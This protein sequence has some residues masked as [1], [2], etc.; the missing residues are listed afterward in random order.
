M[1]TNLIA[2]IVLG[3][4]FAASA[5][6]IRLGKRLPRHHLSPETKEAVRIGMG[7][8]A[9]M[10]ALVLGLLVASAKTA[11]DKEKAEVVQMAGKIAFL[12][13]VLENYGPASAEARE[14]L[15][16]AT[17]AA[18]LRIW[19][20]AQVGLQAPAP[21]NAWGQALPIAIQRLSPSDD[22][23]RYFKS[24][25][26]TLANELGQMRWLLFEQTE[27]SISVP[28]LVMMVFWLAMTFLSVGLFAPPNATVIAAQF[29]AALA[30]AGAVFLVLELDDPFSGLVKISSHSMLSALTTLSH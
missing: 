7:S 6:G 5:L 3:C 18:I 13:Q 21:S 17:Q 11:Y 22:I 26:A 16:R 15:R 8:V 25:A 1:N 12:D 23:Q 19:P 10:A 28:L 27:S 30:V 14:V 4:L 29:L 20:E 9:T 24:Q 2:L